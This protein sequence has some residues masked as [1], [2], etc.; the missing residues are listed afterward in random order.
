MVKKLKANDLDRMYYTDNLKSDQPLQSF[1]NIV[2]FII[3]Y[4]AKNSH[5]DNEEWRSKKLSS[6]TQI[7]VR[8]SAWTLN[9][10]S[11]SHQGCNL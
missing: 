11:V 5:G 2:V 4:V 10:N 3:Y 8:K 6:T 7:Q 9:Y 1:C